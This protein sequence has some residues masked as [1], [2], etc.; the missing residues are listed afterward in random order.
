[1]YRV[2]SSY[3]HLAYPSGISVNSNYPP[4]TYSQQSMMTPASLLPELHVFTSTSQLT[5][6][7]ELWWWTG[8]LELRTD[9]R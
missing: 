4:Y 9:P 3:Y 6:L 1:M 7:L 2:A 5:F 8:I